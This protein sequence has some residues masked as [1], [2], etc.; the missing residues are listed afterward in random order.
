[1]ARW[2]RTSRAHAVNGDRCRKAHAGHCSRQSLS[3]ESADT[4]RS[5]CDCRS[6]DRGEKKNRGGIRVSGNAASGNAQKQRISITKT[7]TQ[8][9]YMLR[10]SKISEN[11]PFCC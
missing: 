4:H 1:M 6:V 9:E 10:H 3:E 2:K 7:V 11:R 5:G 8:D